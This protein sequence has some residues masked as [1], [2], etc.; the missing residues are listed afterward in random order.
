MDLKLEALE[1]IE[2][3]LSNDFWYGVGIG[4]GAVGVVAAIVAT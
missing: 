3:P 1:N 2:A 4:L